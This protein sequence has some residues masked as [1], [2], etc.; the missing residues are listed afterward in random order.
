M[1]SYSYIVKI[2][3]LAPV[4]LI[5]PY[6]LLRWWYRR[7]SP[8]K[9]ES[10]DS[11]APPR[12]RPQ[13][14]SRENKEGDVASITLECKSPSALWCAICLEDCESRGE[15]RRF[16][17]CNH[18]YHEACIHQRLHRDMHCPLCPGSVRGGSVR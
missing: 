4:I 8:Y 13:P 6:L 14:L 5:V 18:A 10:G 3:V 9:T 1:G 16:V 12:P 11:E 17:G 7:R 2:V 15:F